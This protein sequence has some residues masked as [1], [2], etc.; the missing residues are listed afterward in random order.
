MSAPP[1]SD[2]QRLLLLWLGE[3]EFSQYGECQGSA[4]DALIAM[5]LVKLHDSGEQQSTF[6]AKGRSDMHRAVSLTDDGRAIFKL[7]NSQ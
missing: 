7:E 5:G 1:L 2:K 6:I 4:L 3:S